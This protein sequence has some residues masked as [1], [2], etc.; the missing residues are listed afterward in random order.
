MLALYSLA[1]FLAPFSSRADSLGSDV[2]L[3]LAI[4]DKVRQLT[5]EMSAVCPLADPADR[6]AFDRCRAALFQE[7]LLRRTVD[8]LLVWGRPHPTP[9]ESL[10][11]T[12]LT[13]FA[14]EAWIGLYAPLFM[15]NGSWRLDY[16]VGEGLFRA[17]L[18]VLFRNAMDPGQYAY[19]FWHNARKWADYQAANTMVF[20][21]APRPG[22]IVAAQFMNDGE[23]RPGLRSKPV[24]P[25]VF[26]GQWM[27]TDAAGV[28]QPAPTLF[29]GL[30]SDDNPHLPELEP[31]YR[32]LANAMRRAHCN[33]CHV[34]ENP[35]RMKRLVLL[36]TPAHA[37][38]E[39]KRLMKSVRNNEM[40]VDDTLDYREID[41]GTK[42]T[43][44][45]YGAAFEA[46]ID[47]ARSWEEGRARPR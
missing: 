34:P 44:L 10:K 22:R 4:E 37:A 18:G 39:I 33:D 40:P 2:A 42:E 15:F 43:L 1:F 36:Q 27:W 17:R 19:P 30:F 5:E 35:N 31:R 7:S 41:A 32:D 29:Q 16:D 20:W 25:P 45:R 13:Q 38:S 24:V 47:A 11:N 46:L 14:P 9:G 26:D 21:F 28:T 23:D 8:T 6:Q 3:R 12:T